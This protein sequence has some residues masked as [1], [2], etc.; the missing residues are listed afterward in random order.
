MSLSIFNQQLSIPLASDSVLEFLRQTSFWQK[1][2]QASTITESGPFQID[3]QSQVK[4]TL[5][6]TSVQINQTLP[7]PGHPC[8]AIAHWSDHQ[9]TLNYHLTSNSP[10]S[11]L[12]RFSA[13]LDK[14][15]LM[16]QSQAKLIL[17]H[18]WQN[19]VVAIHEAQHEFL[20]QNLQSNVGS[21]STLATTASEVVQIDPV[22]EE[23]SQEP[24]VHQP[25]VVS[26]QPS[27]LFTQPHLPTIP[28]PTQ[29][30]TLWRTVTDWQKAV[31][32]IFTKEHLTSSQWL[33]L[34]FLVELSSDYPS[35]TASQLAKLTGLHK[36]VISDL[37]KQL[38]KKHFLRKL[39][40][41]HNKKEFQ[42]QVTAEGKTV[43][44]AVF[45]KLQQAEKHFFTNQTSTS[46]TIGR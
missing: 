32:P 33:V 11:S 22:E 4:L 9:L 12:L 39:K 44:F 37:A 6:S 21:S 25:P 28:L 14:S 18:H 7:Q 13:Q 1:V 30:F 17:R 20:F 26:P 36:M 38:V 45:G 16:A 15:S 46:T 2:W 8:Q 10:T 42:L 19:F 29:G 40:L 5:F 3:L 43:A 41:S 34:Y 35:L 23:F 27:P 24:S 31:K